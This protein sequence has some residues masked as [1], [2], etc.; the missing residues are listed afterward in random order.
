MRL[1]KLV[2]AVLTVLGTGV[3]VAP[4]ATAADRTYTYTIETRGPVSSDVGYFATMARATF[5]HSAGWGLGGR[6]GFTQVPSGGNFRLIL[7]TPAQ[8]AAASP[9]CSAQWSC[10][11]G[12]LV[13][14][15]E[16]RWNGGSASWPYSVHNYRHYVINHEVGHWLGLGHQNCPGAGAPAPV[17]QQQSISLGGCRAQIWPL[18]F[19][20]ATVAQR[21]GIQSWF[22]DRGPV[23]GGG[24]Q[25]QA[26]EW[27]TSPSDRYRFAMQA[28]G[29]AVLYAGSRVL[30]HS[31]TNGNPGSRIV[32]QGDGNLV[33]YSP[34]GRP[35]WHSVTQ[36]SPGARLVLQD[37]GNLVV[38]ARDNRPLWNTGPDR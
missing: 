22:T 5:A 15:N 6:L 14:I 11:V 25:M 36:G 21:H 18:A 29:N 19:E 2:V 34:A 37:D 24:A 32:M 33:V 35:L 3:V 28:D 7:A 31:R 30:W 17:M 8:V 26:G 13:L 16:Q 20:K 12:E 23:L 10:R 27:L 9:S 4:A 38:Y 1:A